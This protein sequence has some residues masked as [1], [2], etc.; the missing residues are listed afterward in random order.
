MNYLLVL[1]LLISNFNKN[2][3]LDLDLL[4]PTSE[5]DLAKQTTTTRVYLDF[6][7]FTLTTDETEQLFDVFKTIYQIIKPEPSTEV[8]EVLNNVLIDLTSIKRMI[9]GI[10]TLTQSFLTQDDSKHLPSPCT[11]KRQLISQSTFKDL[12]ESLQLINNKFPSSFSFTDEDKQ[13]QEGEKFQ[14]LANSLLSIK[15]TVHEFLALFDKQYS[16]ISLLQNFEI[17]AETNLNLNLNRCIRTYGKETYRIEKLTFYKEGALVTVKLTQDH[18]FETFQVL[19]PTPIAGIILDLNHLYNPIHDNSTYYHQICSEFHEIKTCQ[20]SVVQN[21]CIDAIKQKHV[22]K[23]L[24]NCPILLTAQIKPFLT[25]NGV[26]IPPQAKLTLLDP[27]THEPSQNHSLNPDSYDVPTLIQSEFTI[28]VDF[29][30]TIY[31]F[32]PTSPDTNIIFSYLT[33]E[34]Y[35]TIYYFLNP[36]LNPDYQIYASL[37]G[38]LTLSVS[39]IIGLTIKLLKPKQSKHKNKR[40][41]A[42]IHKT[43]SNSFK[44]VKK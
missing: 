4:V 41:V 6:K 26:F 37:A 42:S 2:V 10:N 28:Q 18:D 19:K 3:A 23:I 24:L 9:R 35:E 27:A 8:P 33:P 1:I 20:L 16:A 36:L 44:R 39:L 34:D 40:Y 29:N 22:S 14:L 17:P 38:V 43:K 11:F 25:L 5:T 15:G 13:N 32:G 31:L 30:D 21:P 12:I 7:I